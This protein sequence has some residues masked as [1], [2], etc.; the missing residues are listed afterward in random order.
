M[1]KTPLKRRTPLRPG[2][3]FSRTRKPLRSRSRKRRKH[4]TRDPEWLRAYGSV[5]RV[6][7][8]KREPCVFCGARPCDNAHGASGGTGRKADADTIVAACSGPGNCHW[9]MDHGIGKKAMERKHGVDLKVAARDLDE[10][11]KARGIS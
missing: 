10:R 6:D 3:G 4:H 8:V 7:A 9:Q 11:L 5:E 1:R 2:K